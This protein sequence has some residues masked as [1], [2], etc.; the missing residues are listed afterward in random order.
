MLR[1]PPGPLQLRAFPWTIPGTVPV[2]PAC[3]ASPAP[4]PQAQSLRF[5]TARWGRW[6]VGMPT[7]TARKTPPGVSRR[8]P[9]PTQTHRRPLPEPSEFKTQ[10]RRDHIPP[11]R[12]LGLRGCFWERPLCH[13]TT[14]SFLNSCFRVSHT[15]GPQPGS[16]RPG[17][18]CLHQAQGW[19]SPFLPVR[20]ST[21]PTEMS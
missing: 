2:Q 1:G 13:T 20:E 14:N 11:R 16:E 4:E 5:P 12:G 3:A 6:A 10:G 21:Y 9:R 17:G 15:Q 18:L 19:A 7:L 8:E